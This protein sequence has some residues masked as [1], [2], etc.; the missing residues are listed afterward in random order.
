MKKIALA[1]LVTFFGTL[2][3]ATEPTATN[4][5]PTTDTQT[6]TEPATPPT[7]TRKIVKKKKT[8]KTSAAGA[9][10]SG[11]TGSAAGTS[12]PTTEPQSN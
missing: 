7:G 5:E 2:S 4:T 11:A 10:G 9:M 12:N 1:L 6:S 8:T 3:L